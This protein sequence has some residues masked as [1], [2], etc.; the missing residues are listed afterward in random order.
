MIRTNP[1][2]CARRHRPHA[3]VIMP[4]GK[5][6]GADGSLYDFNAIYTQL[7]KPTLES[8]GFE[9]FRADEES[10]QRRYPH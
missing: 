10:I 6:K 2:P 7:I 8:V 9:S 1:T 4:F 5:K 3:F